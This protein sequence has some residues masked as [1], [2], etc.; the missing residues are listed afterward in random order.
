MMW[1]AN[2][3]WQGAPGSSTIT[4][5]MNT[6]LEHASDFTIDGDISFTADG[7]ITLTE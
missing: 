5:T 1:K 6:D 2:K 7:E 4:L 3:S